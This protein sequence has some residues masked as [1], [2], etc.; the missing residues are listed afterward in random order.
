M[1]R[2]IQGGKIHIRTYLFVFIYVYGNKHQWRG[3]LGNRFPVFIPVEAVRVKGL[4]LLS[5]H[6]KFQKSFRKNER[7]FLRE[8]M[9]YLPKEAEVCICWNCY[10]HI[11]EGHCQKRPKVENFIC[12]ALLSKLLCKEK[13]N[14]INSLAWMYIPIEDVTVIANYLG[15]TCSVLWANLVC[16]AFFWNTSRCTC[17]LLIPNNV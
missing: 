4:I 16:L 17:N 9:K 7:H 1:D 13:A 11:L 5:K 3:R 10:I 2:S 6:H 12:I 8:Y 14:S 15:E